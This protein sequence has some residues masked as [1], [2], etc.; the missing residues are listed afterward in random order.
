MVVSVEVL[1]LAAG[2]GRRCGMVG[3]WDW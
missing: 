3:G 1:K 2:I